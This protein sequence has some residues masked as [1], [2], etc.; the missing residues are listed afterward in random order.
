MTADEAYDAEAIYDVV[1][2][3]H[4]KAAIIIAARITPVANETIASQRAE[5]KVG[6]NVP[7][8][9]TGLGMPISAWTADAVPCRRSDLS[10]NPMRSILD[11]GV[12][13]AGLAC[14][15]LFPLSR[16]ESEL[17]G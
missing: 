10:S 6:C 2:E 15:R 16:N 9:V 11:K 17:L 12:S 13:A 7:N 3:R 5:A 1:A 14:R 8:R 4:P